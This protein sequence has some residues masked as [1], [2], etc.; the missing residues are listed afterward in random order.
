MVKKVTTAAVVVA[1]VFCGAAAAQEAAEG[2]G[3]EELAQ[4]LEETREALENAN[5]RITELEQ[6]VGGIETDLGETEAEL[7]TQIKKIEVQSREVPAGQEWAFDPYGYIKVDMVHDD[8]QTSGT[9]ATA[10]VLPETPGNANDRHFTITARQT[11]LGVN[12][13]GPD[14]GEATSAGKIEVDFYAPAS[15]EN[16]AELMLR[17]AYWK[18]AYPNWNLTVGQQWEIMSPSF[19]HILNYAYLALSGNPGY[20]KPMVRYQRNDKVWGEKTLTT[21]LGIG[22]G[23]GSNVVSSA[24]LDDEAS[25]SGMPDFQG[26][27]GLS[28]PTRY[29]R[30]VV[31]GISGHFGREEYDPPVGNN[32]TM[33]DSSSGNLDWSVPL[34]RKLD[35]NGEFWS[36]RNLDGYMAGIGQGVDTTLGKAVDATGGWGQLC[37]HHSEK[38]LFTAGAGIDDVE[39]EDISAGGR[40]RNETYFANAIYNINKRTRVGCEVSYQETAWKGISDGDNVRVQTSLQFDY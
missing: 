1:L 6:K 9:G 4:Q 39:D 34:C 25:D 40:E 16:K 21:D 3:S 17:Q 5:R 24:W 31:V 13:A 35:F 26:R 7:S 27:I 30:P 11:R 20:R 14:V 15:V 36:G 23:I 22:R 37:W 2:P 12:I 19:P 28:C 8:T 38:W 18:L 29:E 10:F 33:Y 32:G